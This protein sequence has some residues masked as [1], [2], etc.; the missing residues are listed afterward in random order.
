[1]TARTYVPVVFIM[2]G[3]I[4]AACEKKS[5]IPLRRDPTIMP[6][7]EHRDGYRF[8]AGK[9]VRVSLRIKQSGEE[10]RV[11][12]RRF[13]RGQTV[14][15]GYR[16]AYSYLIDPQRPDIQEAQCS[17]FLGLI[18]EGPNSRSDSPATWPKGAK[19]PVRFRTSGSPRKGFF[20][21]RSVKPGEEQ[22]LFRLGPHEGDSLDLR[23]S[24]EALEE[25]PVGN[26]R[27]ETGAAAAG[28]G[29]RGE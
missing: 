12:Q 21:I 15:F 11:L 24:V 4:L 22:L 14:G 7:T 9:P 27:T 2:S 16:L 10:D 20:H 13:D 1:M 3:S 6:H 23:V 19:L 25:E 29:D 17:V 18:E 28:G 5:G 26:P 8:V